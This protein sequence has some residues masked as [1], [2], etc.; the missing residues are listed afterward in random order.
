MRLQLPAVT[1]IDGATSYESM[2][3]KSPIICCVEVQTA[4]GAAVIRL[5]ESTVPEL[6]DQLQS[7]LKV[8]AAAKADI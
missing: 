1:K 2:A 3:S 8:R 5:L 4:D 6:R 7:W